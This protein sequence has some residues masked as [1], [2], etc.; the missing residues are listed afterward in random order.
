MTTRAHVTV[1]LEVEHLLQWCMENDP[2]F[3]GAPV[4]SV[5]AHFVKQ[6]LQAA[7]RQALEQAP[8]M[9]AEEFA[10]LVAGQRRAFKEAGEGSP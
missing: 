1:P 6:G 5:L 2:Q 4:A 7:Y 8:E 9:D 10:P 3:L